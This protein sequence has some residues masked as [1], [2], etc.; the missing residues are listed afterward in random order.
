MNK[1]KLVLNTYKEY[2][3]TDAF[4][5]LNKNINKVINYK[6][7]NGTTNIF[8]DKD[9]LTSIIQVSGIVYNNN[10]YNKLNETSNRKLRD[11]ITLAL[12]HCIN[13]DIYL[14][15]RKTKEYNL[16]EKFSLN[17]F[18]EKLGKILLTDNGKKTFTINK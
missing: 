16:M 6:D 10:I 8:C 7:I 5:T 15:D 12:K 17:K 1:N 13:L 9:L 11:Y 4:K 2:A 18:F 14:V 3:Y